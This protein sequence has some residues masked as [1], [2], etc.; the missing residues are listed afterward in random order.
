MYPS[1]KRHADLIEALKEQCGEPVDERFFTTFPAKRGLWY[2]KPSTT[3]DALKA[4]IEEL[5]PCEGEHEPMAVDD[6]LAM[7]RGILARAEEDRDFVR[8]AY[9]KAAHGNARESADETARRWDVDSDVVVSP[10]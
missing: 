3:I 2:V 4:A 9:V 6:A 5:A 7:L 10:F 1:E 8:M